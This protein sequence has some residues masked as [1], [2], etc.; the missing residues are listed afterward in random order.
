[1]AIPPN[2]ND[3]ESLT[4]LLKKIHNKEVREFFKEDLPEDEFSNPESRLKYECL[5]Q[6]DDSAIRTLQRLFFFEFKMPRFIDK[7]CSNIRG[8]PIDDIREY[9]KPQ[10]ELYFEEIKPYDNNKA[11]PKRIKKWLRVFKNPEDITPLD[12]Q[13]LTQ[14]INL[15][16]PENYTHYCG[17]E[18]YSYYDR[19]NIFKMIVPARSQVDASLMISKMCDIQDITFKESLMRKHEDVSNIENTETIRI[20]NE[21]KKKYKNRNYGT[22]K[23]K[24]AFLD[25]GQYKSVPLIER[26]F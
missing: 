24:T 16:F 25:I 5:I 15:K 9:I 21:T 7:I 22:V 26:F 8:I 4:D 10:L 11:K 19:F 23:L 14:K 17:K 3:H 6:D 20:L 13:Q 2:V 12:I 1:M 18:G